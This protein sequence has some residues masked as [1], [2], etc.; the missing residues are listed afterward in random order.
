MWYQGQFPKGRLRQ[1]TKKTDKEYMNY[2][3]KMGHAA[4]G[5]LLP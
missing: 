3:I 1:T 4:V 2:L 5:W